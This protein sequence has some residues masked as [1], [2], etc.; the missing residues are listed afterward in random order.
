MKSP[1]DHLVR[2]ALSSLNNSA[3]S[4]GEIARALPWLN[5]EEFG[6]WFSM[7]PRD[8]RHSLQVHARFADLCP[9]ASRDEHAAALLHDVGKISSGLGWTLRVIATVVGSRGA[10]FSEYHN[11]AAIG[12]EML[13]GISSSRTIE[14]VAEKVDDEVSRALYSADNI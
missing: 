7:P 13:Q 4:D 12:A 11:H 5:A 1:I 10:R 6:L 3:L 2:R 14:L 8:C 9:S